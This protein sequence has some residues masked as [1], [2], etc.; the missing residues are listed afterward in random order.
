MKL[1]D[2]TVMPPVIGF[3]VREREFWKLAFSDN[4]RYCHIFRKMVRD[5]VQ[6]NGQL[7][8]EHGI[9]EFHIKIA[10]EDRPAS[11]SVWLTPEYEHF[12]LKYLFTGTNTGFPTYLKNDTIPNPHPDADYFYK[13]IKR[14]VERGAAIF[15]DEELDGIKGTRVMA[16]YPFGSIDYG[17]YP[18]AQAD[19][20]AKLATT[21]PYAYSFAPTDIPDLQ[22]NKLPIEERDIAAGQ[23]L[24]SVFKEI[25]SDTII[26]KTICGV[27]AT[28]LE[29]HSERNS[30]IIEPNVPVI[31][32]KE[33]QHPNIIGVYGETMSAEVI[34]QRI[35]EQTGHVKLMTTPDSYPKVINA[36]KQ[37]KIPYLQ[38]Y[39]L[40]FD[41]CEKIVAEVDYRQ[42]ITLPIDDFFKFTHK[43]MVSATPIVIDD[44]R[45]EEQE[46]KI[47]KIRPT[48]D[49]SK[50][51]E[52][53]PTNNVEV[54]LRQTLDGFKESTTP[55]CIFYN[56][57]Q[58]IKELIDSFKI[59]DDT[60]VYCSTD[61]CKELHKEGYKAFDSV[62]DTCG[63]TVLNRYNFF[64]SRFYSA[65][66]ITLDYKPVV[67]MVTQVYKALP[68]QTPYSLIDPETEAIQ[69]VG[70]FR[71]G[72]EQIIH[73]TNTNSQMIYKDKAELETFLKEQHAGF[74]KL[75]DLRKTLT[76]Q[77]ELYLVDQAIERVE[78]KRLGF[79][80]DKGEINY[81]RYNNA[82]LDERLKILYRYP[83]TLYKA[84]CRSGAF[85][86]VSN[87]EYMAYAD[88]ERKELKKQ[89]SKSDRIKL[90]FSLFSRLE[91]SDKYY[92]RQFYQELQ[93][94]YAL[95][96]EAFHTIGLRKV[97]E[98]NFIDSDVRT[99]IKRVR[100]LKQATDE[101]V[102]QEVYAAFTP[103]TA[104]KTAEINS[105][106]Q[107]IYDSHN[108]EYDKRGISN[109][110][111]LYFD[112]TE[113]RT[114]IKRIWKL[115]KKKFQSVT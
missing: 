3:N 81:F 111:T 73:I 39:F 48:Y 44:P 77:G 66:D 104:Y 50:E 51:L 14:E 105:K 46:F 36:L 69:I 113:T 41:E 101:G 38:Q 103:N 70:R 84:Y 11:I 79:V 53:K 29:I 72:T 62:T 18:L 16:K 35:S 108:I 96:Y 19:L 52:L 24:D 7:R 110:I 26:D 64:T 95:Y 88:E 68:Q 76:T 65:V 9:P 91:L 58:G 97:K 4:I 99:E 47:I 93:N 23:H 30:I 2:V 107:A 17:F 115:G 85:K 10:V 1:S 94:E 92:D 100:F 74:H 82:Y 32:G 20:L 40:L 114:G 8:L 55:I 37:L 98:L 87:A 60:H 80:T 59:G 22:N 12:L 90:L 15:R 45:F 63:K 42:H 27:G 43:A 78:Y 6:I 54:M 67:I 49:Y 28:W 102:I 109:H 56:S 75:L 25:P 71:N 61:A 57:V 106:M 112:A 89:K 31:I 21:I 34:K 33:Q 83:A 86:V 13:H 5:G